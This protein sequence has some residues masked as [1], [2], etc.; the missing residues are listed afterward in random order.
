MPH[1][2]SCVHIC[3][4]YL[5]PYEEARASLYE[6]SKL[7]APK[8][9]EK[10]RVNHIQF[11]TPTATAPSSDGSDLT[12][13]VAAIQQQMNNIQSMMQS[14]QAP[15]QTP[16]PTPSYGEVD[17]APAHAGQHM[18]A[19]LARQ[20]PRIRATSLSPTRHPHRAWFSSLSMR[21]LRPCTPPVRLFSVY[22]LRVQPSIRHMSIKLFLVIICIVSILGEAWSQLTR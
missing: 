21:C 3:E 22:S 14:P 6:K 11:S 1:E 20:V 10:P 4:N 19:I 13:M 15:P 17:H 8:E 2:A 7:P 18:L 9:A 12:Q 16:L 5:G